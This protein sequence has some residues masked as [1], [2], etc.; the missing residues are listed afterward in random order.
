MQQVLA[1]ST[2]LDGQH[3][4]LGATR[5]CDLSD[6]EIVCLAEGL[7]RNSGD[8]ETAIAVFGYV[9]DAI[10]YE[11]GN[12]QRTA[13]QTLRRGRGT[14]TNSANLM[15]ALLRSLGIPAA[16]GVMVVRGREYF[17]PAIPPR[18]CSK[19]GERSRHI[20]VCVWIEG[21]WVRCDPSDDA[22]LSLASQHVNPQ[23]TLIDWDGWDD[24]LLRLDPTHI[25]EDHHPLPDID[26]MLAKPM[27]KAMRIPVHIGNY[28]I[29]FL[30][31]QGE[32]LADA[33]DTHRRFEQWL[34]RTHPASYLAYLMLPTDVTN[35]PRHR[36]AVAPPEVQLL[37]RNADQL[38]GPVVHR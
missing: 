2:A 27:R 10:A 25:I 15:V 18:L 33:R 38:T 35:A 24:A 12:W 9:R 31:E 17:G 32:S 3:A 30:R 7:R 26:A 14:C 36:S 11:V 21:R 37:S 19:T 6:P 8:R 28:F 4:F 23:C 16:Y 34:A 22:A 1:T 20:Y 5:F 29:E 13:S